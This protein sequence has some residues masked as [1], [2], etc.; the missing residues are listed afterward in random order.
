MASTTKRTEQSVIEPNTAQLR[1]EIPSG[2]TPSKTSARDPA[3]APFDTDDEAAGRPAPPE[4][5]QRALA[6]ENLRRT[7]EINRHARRGPVGKLAG[8]VL[9]IG[10]L[11]L[12]GLV[13]AWLM[14]VA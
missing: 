12:A 8:V 10:L 3:M 1:D 7:Q 2:R 13:V 11:T 4:A 5:V 9:L 6:E 14:I